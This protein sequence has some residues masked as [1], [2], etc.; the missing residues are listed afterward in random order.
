MK[1]K[2][3][4]LVARKIIRNI[5][6]NVINILARLVLFLVKLPSVLNLKKS[7]FAIFGTLNAISSHESQI[8]FVTVKDEKV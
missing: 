5:A 7:I 3:N 4:S 6:K 2:D 1:Q 8:I